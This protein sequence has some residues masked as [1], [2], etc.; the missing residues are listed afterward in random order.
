MHK[1]QTE[2]LSSLVIEVKNFA[3]KHHYNQD[4][5][6]LKDSLRANSITE[7][8]YTSDKWQPI[9]SNSLLLFHAINRITDNLFQLSIY[10]TK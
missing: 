9:I 6:L 10:I 1:K 2:N 8:K 5:F 3:Q 7:S 4:I